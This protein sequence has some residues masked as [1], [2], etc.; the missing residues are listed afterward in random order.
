MC[1]SSRRRKSLPSVDTSV[2]EELEAQLKLSSKPAQALVAA[3]ITSRAEQRSLGSV[4]AYAKA[5][6]QTP[7]AML[8]LLWA[9]EGALSC[10]SP[11][12]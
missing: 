1:S 3:G 12:C 6:Q 8:T 2:T 9:L 7:Q 4:V 5:T 10:S 11:A